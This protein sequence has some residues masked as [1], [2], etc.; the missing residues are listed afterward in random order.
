MYCT[1]WKASGQIMENL[2]MDGVDQHFWQGRERK[3]LA[4]DLSEEK[5]H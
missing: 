1:Q 4:K 5:S 3:G 2:G